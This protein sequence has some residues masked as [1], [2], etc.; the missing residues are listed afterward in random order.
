MPA[1]DEMKTNRPPPLRFITRKAGWLKMEAAVEMDAQHPP[2]VVDG[3]FVE[4]ECC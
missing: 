1:D 4:R 2:P 3:Q